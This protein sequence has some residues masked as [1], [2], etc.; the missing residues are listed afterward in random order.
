MGPWRRSRALSAAIQ[1][2]AA[3]I[4]TVDGQTRRTNL[5]RGPEAVA[6][7]RGDHPLLLAETLSATFGHLVGVGD[8][9]N[10]RT[11]ALR[12]RTARRNT[13][14]VIG[15]RETLRLVPNSFVFGLFEAI[16]DPINLS[17]ADF[18][19]Q[20][21]SD[22]FVGSPHMLHAFDDVQPATSAHNRTAVRVL[23][24]C[25]PAPGGHSRVVKSSTR[26]QRSVAPSTRTIMASLWLQERPRTR[27]TAAA[28]LDRR[29]TAFW[30]HAVGARAR[31]LRGQGAG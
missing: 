19:T 2:P 22:A 17:H 27:R 11:G 6:T 23:G 15:R 14:T 8:G 24:D 9:V 18:A 10:R 20:G 30:A 4:G 25:A 3:A 1:P 26:D 29:M 7:G 13:A 5:Y 28:W 31:L 12:C 16:W 21:D